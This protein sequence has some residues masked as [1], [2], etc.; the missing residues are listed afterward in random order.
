M[1]LLLWLTCRDVAVQEVNLR[2]KVTG[3]P[4]SDF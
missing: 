3:A 1:D 2:K 4:L